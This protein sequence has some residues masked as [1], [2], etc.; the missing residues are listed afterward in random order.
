MEKRVFQKGFAASLAS[1]LLPVII[2]AAIVWVVMFALNQ[3]EESSRAESLRM[4]EEAV[5]RAAIHSYAVNGHF[6]ESLEHLTERYDIFIDSS[7]FVVHYDVAGINLFP[8]IVV[9]YINE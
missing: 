8:N 9:L 3:A 1:I 7:R 4:L 5:F 6:P 2:V